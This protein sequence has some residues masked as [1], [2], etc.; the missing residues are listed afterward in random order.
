[1]RRVKPQAMV[2]SNKD[3]GQACIINITLYTVQQEQQGH[4]QVPQMH[5]CSNHTSDSDP[6]QTL[7]ITQQY[8]VTHAHTHIFM[9]RH[10]RIIIQHV[11][12]HVQ[13]RNTITS[14]LNEQTTL[15]CMY[16]CLY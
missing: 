16:Q 10:R 1:M 11:S 12:V 3:Q 6:S 4:I 13:S 7:S 2:R 15:T 5:D 14:L 8:N 9:Q